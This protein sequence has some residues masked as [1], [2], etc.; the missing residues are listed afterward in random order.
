MH[1]NL[2]PT[3]R[4]K[5]FHLTRGLY[6]S[7]GASVL[8]NGINFCIYCAHGTSCELVLYHIG[9]L[10]PFAVIPFPEDYRVGNV[11]AM[12]VFDLDYTQI[13]YGY[14]IDGKVDV[15]KGDVYDP[16]KTLLDPY[17]K[18]VS[19]RSEWG[20]MPDLDNKFQYRSRITLPHLE[21]NPNIAP[22]LD[23]NELIIYEVHMRGF[24]QHKS[25]K[26][27]NPG[28]YAGFIEKIPYLK[29][30]GINAVEFLPIF[31]FDESEDVV[32]GGVRYNSK[33]ERLLNYWGYNPVSFFA[34]KAGYAVFGNY[35]LQIEELKLLITELHSHNIKVI[36]DVVFNHTAEGD[37]RGPYISFKGIDNKAYYILGPN[38]EYYNFSGCGNTLN[39]NNP[40]VRLMILN[41]LR[42]WR[43]EFNVDGFRFDLASILGRNQDGSPMNNPPLLEL[44]TYDP[45]LSNAILIAEA[46]DAGGLYQVGS[47]PSYGGRWAEWNG[48]FR[49]NVRHFIRGDMGY[50]K[51][52]TSRI[53]GSKD[54]YP[55]V[56]QNNYSSINF[57]TCH[58]GFTMWDLFSYNKKHNEE[59]GWNNTDGS[60]DNISWNCGVEGE[61]DDKDI[62][63]LRKQLM[64]NAFTILL[65]SKGI[66][67]LLAGD[68]FCNSQYGNNNAYCQ[69]NEISWLN[70]QMLEDNRDMFEFVK[71]LIAF[72]KAHP[73]LR[74]DNMETP[75]NFPAV[76]Y[77]GLLPWQ[78]D[79]AYTNRIVGILFTGKKDGSDDFIYLG[80][81]A[82]WHDY[83]MRLPALPADYKWQQ[84]ADTSLAEDACFKEGRDVQ[85]NNVTLYSRGIIVCVGV[86]KE[87]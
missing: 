80:I 77:H 59:N 58:D 74:N 36:L 13:E 86:K 12:I 5:N 4:Y 28:T 47:F 24:T 16:T 44:L 87:A 56:N 51:A 10:E 22:K 34:P 61:T 73:L 78:F 33:G 14:R 9:E 55:N 54:L 37:E 7:N 72:R 62:I 49:D 45:L 3:D 41:C 82:H 84:V 20:K 35:S 27:E 29:E 69:D 39:C 19:G 79:Y 17:A 71:G 57:I 21:P 66:P 30:L 65:L 75:E 83:Q 76:S 6:R 31:E 8:P 32:S 68:E 43:S 1:K 18:I 53:S 60:N 23:N 50:A 25:A 48:V 64:R 67:M 40:V 26:C 85:N 70:W 46:W 52:L 81:N 15:A 63:A 2:V 42:Y 38:G 11:Y